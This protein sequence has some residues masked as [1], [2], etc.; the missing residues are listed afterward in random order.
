MKCSVAMAEAAH[1]AYFADEEDVTDV[2]VE[3]M[4]QAVNAALAAVSQFD[5]TDAMCDA[6]GH[7]VYDNYDESS[8]DTMR[9]ALFVALTLA[10]P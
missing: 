3:C 1:Y 9:E 10:Q 4:G 5:V 6:V 8:R 7:I 2:E